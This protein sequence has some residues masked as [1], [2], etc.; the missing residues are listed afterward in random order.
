MYKKD[1]YEK[2]SAVLLKRQSD[3]VERAEEQKEKF[4]TI[5]PQ[6]RDLEFELKSTYSKIAVAVMRGGNVKEELQKLRDKN[7]QTQTSYNLLLAQFGLV[8]EDV[9]PKFVCSKCDDKGNIDGR[10]CICHRELL[11]QIAYDELNRN[12]PLD[13]CGFEKFSTEYYKNIPAEQARKMVNILNY[14]KTYAQNFSTSSPSLLF[15]GGTGLGKTHLS[16]SIA[17]EVIG[18]GFG[19]IYGSV[20]NFAV[21]IE[22][23][24][25]EQSDENDTNNMLCS[26]DLLILDD[27]GTE[28]SSS[29]TISVIYNIINTRIMK[30]L[31]TLISTNLS[32]PELEKRY[33]ERLISRL[34]GSY[35]LLGFVGQDIRTFKKRM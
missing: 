34:F 29:Y 3:A 16:L 17:K 33:S 18:K 26:C 20:Q 11:T 23:E 5:C 25:F 8:K 31:P 13:E 21:A 32:A 22:K 30:K 2:A 28:F 10:M 6:A 24:R 35:N 12:T 14:C 4:Y 9:S 1:V 15:Q 7:L 27:L 19:V